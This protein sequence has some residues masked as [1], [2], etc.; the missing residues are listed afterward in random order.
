MRSSV[1]R[2]LAARVLVLSL[3]WGV[4][5][6]A[7]SA[8]SSWP[9]LEGEDGYG[10]RARI[11]REFRQARLAPA[12]Y[13]ELDGYG[14]RAAAEFRSRWPVTNIVVTRPAHSQNSSGSSTRVPSPPVVTAPTTTA[15][16]VEEQSPVDPDAVPWTLS[17]PAI[18]V[19]GR[20]EGGDDSNAIVDRGLIWH[21][22]G[23]GT[24]AQNSH[25][26]VF[27]HRTSKGGLFRNIHQL[28]AGDTIVITT[29][30]GRSFSYAVTGSSVVE[31]DARSIFGAASQTPGRTV[32][33]VACSRLDGTPTSL[34]YRIVV[35]ASFIG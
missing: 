4:L 26:V 13:G 22:T 23:T 15:A 24:M 6:P 32:S 31:P 34:D 1:S 27:A 33:L 28:D 5:S 21:W 17:I 25:V 11:D 10:L 9:L 8:L 19:S 16:P 3:L 2:S 12:T 14:V 20:V 30:D 29:V 7:G 35:N 18:G